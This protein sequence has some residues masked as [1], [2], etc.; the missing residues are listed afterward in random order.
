MLLNQKVSIMEGKNVNMNEVKAH[1]KNQI[2]YLKL[3][4]EYLKLQVEIMQYRLMLESLVKD[5]NSQEGGIL[6]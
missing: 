2:S 6:R 3:E 4:H 1:L 5:L